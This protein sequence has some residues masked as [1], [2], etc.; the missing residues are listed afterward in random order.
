MDIHEDYR[1]H[2]LG[3]KT[4]KLPLIATGGLTAVTPNLVAVMAVG[5]HSSFLGFDQLRP[6]WQSFTVIGGLCLF[7]VFVVLSHALNLAPQNTTA[8]NW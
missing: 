5:G 2:S 8:R 4:G 7:A 6:A 1:P 3:S